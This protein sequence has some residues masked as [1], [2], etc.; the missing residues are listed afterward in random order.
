MKCGVEGD[1]VSPGNVLCPVVCSGV[2]FF[3]AL[4]NTPIMF[5]CTLVFHNQFHDYTGYATYF[6]I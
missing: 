5:V 2:P 6:D 4:T 3:Y 1:P